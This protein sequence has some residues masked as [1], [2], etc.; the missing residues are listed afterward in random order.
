MFKKKEQKFINPYDRKWNDIAN[1]RFD[2]MR[3]IDKL[4]AEIQYSL[5]VV[6]CFEENS[7]N[8]N[9]E[10]KHLKELRYAMLCECGAFDGT[11]YD[12]RKLWKDHNKLQPQFCIDYEDLTVSPPV[13]C[14]GYLRSAAKNFKKYR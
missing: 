13:D 10:N 12:L 11:S 3:S 7:P 5:D 9:A 1:H 2:I 14:N 8:W 6:S 4:Y